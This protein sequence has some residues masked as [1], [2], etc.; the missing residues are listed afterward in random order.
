MSEPGQNEVHL[1]Q[2]REGYT[3][4]GSSEVVLP[5]GTVPLMLGSQASAT[6]EEAKTAGR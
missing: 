2:G 3:G 4:M 1:A 6:N 5:W